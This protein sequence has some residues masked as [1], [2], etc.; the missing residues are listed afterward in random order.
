MNFSTGKRKTFSNELPSPW[1]EY[2]I[3]G[4][5]EGAERNFGKG[6][7]GEKLRMTLF[8]KNEKGRGSRKSLLVH[9]SPFPSP[10]LKLLGL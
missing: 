7:M 8:Y 5:A 3:R 2:P 4:T 1:E 10:P 9:G 6:K